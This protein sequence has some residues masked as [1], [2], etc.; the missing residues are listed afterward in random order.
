MPAYP[1]GD[2][3]VNFYPFRAEENCVFDLGFQASV[4]AL[5][6]GSTDTFTV[7]ITLNT[8]D[9]MLAGGI[10][11]LFDQTKLEVVG[12]NGNNASFPVTE[13]GSNI[14]NKYKYTATLNPSVSTFWPLVYRNDAAFKAKWGAVNIVVTQ[15]TT[16]GLPRCVTT[17][18]LDESILQFTF[19]LKAG[20][21]AGEAVIYIDPA[22]KRDALNRQNALY[23]SRAKNADAMVVYD[24]LASY[25]TTVDVTD[26]RA[27]VNIVGETTITIDP[28]NGQPTSQIAGF[29]GAVTPQVADPVWEGHTFTGWN[30]PIPAHFPM[31]SFTAVAQWD[32]N[33]YSAVF[34]VDGAEYA[35][36]PTQYGAAIQAPADPV[37]EGYT[38][39]GW[40][41]IPAT[42][43]A[44]DVEINGSFSINTYDAIF[45]SDGA[46]YQTVPTQYGAVIQVPADPVK[47]G[48]VFEGWLPVPGTMGA[49]DEVFVA[50]WRQNVDIINVTNNNVY[51]F[52]QYTE[53]TVL[54]KGSPCKIQFAS[55]NNLANTLTYWRDINPNILSIT[56]TMFDYGDGPMPCETWVIRVFISMSDGEWLAR[57]KYGDP[58]GPYGLWYH[59]IFIASAPLDAA[60]YDI[61]IDHN[62]FVFG[63]TSVITIKTGPDATK[64]RLTNPAGA[65]RTYGIAYSPY[66]D[67]GGFRYWTITTKFGSLGP[68]SWTVVA[69]DV[70][71]NANP[72]AAPLTFTVFQT[73]VPIDPGRGVIS[74]ALADNRVLWNIPTNVTVTTEIDCTAVLVTR[75]GIVQR[76]TP[77]NAT[78]V[79]EAGTRVW[80][81]PVIFGALGERTYTVSAMFGSVVAASTKDFTVTVLY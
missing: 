25:G 17:N 20:A 46:V 36:V 68:N 12:N 32:V 4:T 45:K 63:A 62:K 57:A 52:G 71:G 28:A 15:D 74:V 16:S 55:A 13:L 40:S 81:V 50:Q 41:Q 18:G 49:G 69:Y 14:A 77:A 2:A 37:K 42:M 59:S 3:G 44:Q 26:A 24:T 8:V 80:T 73:E 10:P 47:E 76:F 39:S 1:Y 21:T 27:V 61:Q 72:A 78:Y 33:S 65:T 38:F 35:T 6:V 60:V 31:T 66:V 75:N 34:K 54:V 11:F 58:L 67:Q 64:V 7:T 53:F 43:P 29:P 30:P 70:K 19:R 56:P 48:Y 79:D 51:K 22:F 9:L 23:L 5:P